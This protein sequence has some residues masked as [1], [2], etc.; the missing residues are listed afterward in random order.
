MNVSPSDYI[1]KG[2]LPRYRRKFSLSVNTQVI[3]ENCVIFTGL[4][5]STNG[6]C[7]L[8]GSD[9]ISDSNKYK[10]FFLYNGRN[11]FPKK[12]EQRIKPTIPLKNKWVS[13]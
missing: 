3:V 7:C 12:F 10:T 9:D 11:F 8:T 1:N 6:T 5:I 13:A 2:S 4:H